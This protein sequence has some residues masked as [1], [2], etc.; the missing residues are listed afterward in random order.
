MIG[1]SFSS[2]RGRAPRKG[3]SSS[4]P[5][6]AAAAAAADHRLVADGCRCPY[7]R[8]R[9]R[10]PV[11]ACR[12]YRGI[13]ASPRK[14]QETMVVFATILELRSARVVAVAVGGAWGDEVWCC[15][16]HRIRGTEYFGLFEI[17][18][19]LVKFPIKWMRANRYESFFSLR[20]PHLYAI[21]D[22]ACVLYGPTYRSSRCTRME[23]SRRSSQQVECYES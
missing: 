12:Y 6:A 7:G 14:R 17:A 16:A 18:S 23:L 4:L 13:V 19:S 1:H 5:V 8:C 3:W 21:R 22:S 11:E 9:R 15:P 10:Y 20:P 2:L